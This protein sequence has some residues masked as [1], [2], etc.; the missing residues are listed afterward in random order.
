[1]RATAAV[2]LFTQRCG[3][4]GNAY[5]PTWSELPPG[6]GSAPR[7]PARSILVVEYRDGVRVSYR[8]AKVVAILRDLSESVNDPERA[9]ALLADAVEAEPY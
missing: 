3:A 1:M 7:Q 5:S 4:A 2:Q 9:R 6:P 8:P